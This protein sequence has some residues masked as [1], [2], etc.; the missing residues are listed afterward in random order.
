VPGASNGY[1]FIRASNRLYK[2]K[3]HI[4]AGT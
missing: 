1:L 3:A 2:R 4:Q